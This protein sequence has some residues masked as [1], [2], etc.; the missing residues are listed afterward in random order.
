M[1]ALSVLAG[2]NAATVSCKYQHNSVIF[3]MWLYL[4]SL[5]FLLPDKKALQATRAHVK[6]SKRAP[7]RAPSII[8]I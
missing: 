6:A 2:M 3:I 8:D 5:F 7:V 4:V 1:A